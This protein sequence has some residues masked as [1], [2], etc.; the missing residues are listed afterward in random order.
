MA[1]AERLRTGRPADRSG[2]KA[3]VAEAPQPATRRH[4]PPRSR[5]PGSGRALTGTRVRPARTCI[6]RARLSN[7]L[8]P[9][10]PCGYPPPGGGLVPYERAGRNLRYTPTLLCD[11]ERGRK[12]YIRAVC[13][14]DELLRV[15][16]RAGSV[17]YSFLLYVSV[18]VLL[19]SGA[20]AWTMP[21]ERRKIVDDGRIV[22]ASG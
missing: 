19:P 20:G 13:R 16:Y 10:R 2:S 11:R 3:P 1:P 18:V 9:P 6:S 8:R 17:G 22:G 4:L 12:H 7:C 14:N 15:P 21:L 5:F